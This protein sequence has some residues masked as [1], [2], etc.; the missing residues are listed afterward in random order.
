MDGLNIWLTEMRKRWPGTK[1]IT[2]GEFGM[3]WREKFKDNNA[4][5]YRFVQRGSGVCA[6]DP[7]L[8]IR[9]FMNK[10]FRLAL[11]KNRK[12]NSSEKVIDF[13]GMKKSEAE[14]LL[15]QELAE[16]VA[17]ASLCGLGKSA[18]N[19]VLS[20]LRYFI[21][22]YTAHVHSRQCPAGVCKALITYAID[23]E[24]CTGCQSCVKVCPTGAIS[25][26]RS[27]PH[28]LDTTK[29]IKCRSCYEI[30]RFDA[31][32]GAAIEI[33]TTEKKS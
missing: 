13:H 28:N 12:E 32:A 24:K 15:L 1:G 11:L 16:T 4:M 7:D 31:I 6:S 26:P 22:E 14:R 23:A 9:W 5:N 8:E 27:E 2:H 30:C 17:E 3:A 33:H 19:P 18:P 10:D 29:C 21:D 25:G 20:T